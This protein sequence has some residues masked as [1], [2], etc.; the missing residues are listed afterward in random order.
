MTQC[1]EFSLIALSALAC[2]L[3]ASVEAKVFKTD[4]Y[5]ASNKTSFLF[6]VLRAI[7][8]VAGLVP[9]GVIREKLLPLVLFPFGDEWVF[10]LKRT[11]A[12][13]VINFHGFGMQRWISYKL[14]LI[15][16][17]IPSGR[18]DQAGHSKK[19]VS[20]SVRRQSKSRSK[21]PTKRTISP[22]KRTRSPRN[23]SPKKSKK[24]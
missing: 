21:S 20:F 22:T 13:S 4:K 24:D 3:G 15:N 18:N 16:T 12:T 23:K 19:K 7:V 1:F 5:T 14:G 17:S 11:I 9:S 2:L 10:A 6:T 8:I